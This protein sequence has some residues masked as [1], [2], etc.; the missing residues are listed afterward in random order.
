MSLAEITADDLDLDRHLEAV[1]GAQFGAVVTFIGQI[2][3]HD[4]EASGAVERLEYSAHPD[5]E[6]ILRRIA[7]ELERPGIRIAVSHRTGTVKVGEPAL[8]ACV[9]A[10]HRELAYEVSRELVERVKSE[11]PIWKQQIA[12]DGSE[13]WQGLK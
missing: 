13:N 1:D 12:A 5:A 10:A 11:V 9:A 3:D 6:E 4:P 7:T 2:R 8:V